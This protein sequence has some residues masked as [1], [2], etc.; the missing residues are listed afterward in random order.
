MSL[1]GNITSSVLGLEERRRIIKVNK[2]KLVLPIGRAE[3]AC[4]AWMGLDGTFLPW[5]RGRK[6]TCN[7]FD[8]H[9][10]VQLMKLSFKVK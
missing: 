1:C 2:D 8:N 10:H 4:V 7:P 5:E 6:V 3:L 9:F